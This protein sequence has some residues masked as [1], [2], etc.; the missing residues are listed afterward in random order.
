MAAPYYDEI[1][2]QASNFRSISGLSDSEPVDCKNLLLRFNILTVYKKMSEE[3]S[4]MCLKRADKKFILINSRH[5][6]GRQHFTIGHELYHLF[7]QKEFNTHFCNPGSQTKD[8]NE[9]KADLFSS[10][11]LMPEIGIK[12]N[13]PPNELKKNLSIATLLR[14]ERIFSV[15]HIA[16]IIRLKDLGIIDKNQF[17]EFK[18]LP[19]S[20]VAIYYGFNT[21]L[22]ENGNDGLVIGDYGTLAKKRFDEGCISEGHYR[23]LMSDIGIDLT[24]ID[25][26]K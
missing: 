3:F 10:I 4:G 2:I 9:K 14:L 5:S 23:E 26:D 13:I 16:M 12:K 18:E 11:L 19:L 15:S 6:K 8:I 24:D 17:Q 7:I 22:Y 20:R 25:H 21:S 1:E